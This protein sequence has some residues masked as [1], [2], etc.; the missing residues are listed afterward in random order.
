MGNQESEDYIDTDELLHQALKRAAE[1]RPDGGSELDDFVQLA[2]ALTWL[3]VLAAPHL[4]AQLTRAPGRD[5]LLRQVDVF[6]S[7]ARS[8]QR[9]TTPTFEGVPYEQR[10][11]RA[12]RLRQLLEQWVSA[13]LPSKIT[14][15]SR[16]LL[17]AEG[18]LPPEGWDALPAPS[19]PIEECLSWP[20]SEQ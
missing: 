4:F 11:S 10:E 16:E 15:A 5:H 12:M 1:P 13:D 6:L 8:G 7:Y 14:E 17:F 18:L 3:E 20:K 2:H 19:R 9:H